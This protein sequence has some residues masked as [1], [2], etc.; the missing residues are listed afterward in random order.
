ML[1]TLCLFFDKIL[2]DTRGGIILTSCLIWNYETALHHISWKHIINWKAKDW[3]RLDKYASHMTRPWIRT[4]FPKTWYRNTFSFMVH[5]FTTSVPVLIYFQW[6]YFKQEIHKN[7]HFFNRPIPNLIGTFQ[8]FIRNNRTFFTLW[9]FDLI[10]LSYINNK[11]S[12]VKYI[13]DPWLL[14]SVHEV[15]I[16]NESEND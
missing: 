6:C 9:W 3:L 8:T 14:P 1:L 13:I 16:T 10:S 5:S 7:K 2:R 15:T 12:K 4:C 11:K